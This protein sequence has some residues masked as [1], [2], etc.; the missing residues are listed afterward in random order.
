MRTPKRI[1]T[2][3]VIASLTMF[4]GCDQL[5]DVSNPNSLTEEDVT[6]PASANGLKNGLLHS[7]MVGTAW[8]WAATST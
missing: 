1:I 3:L 5:L 7:L 2:L 6:Q 4:Y 8:T